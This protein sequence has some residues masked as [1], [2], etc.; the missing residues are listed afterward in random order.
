MADNRDPQAIGTPLGA[1]GSRVG[2]FARPALGQPSGLFG[3][4]ESANVEDRR[5]APQYAPYSVDQL[6]RQYNE[7]GAL[8]RTE[9]TKARMRDMLYEF[10]RR[11]ALELQ[12]SNGVD[13]ERMG[14]LGAPRADGGEVSE[15]EATPTPWYR[16]IANAALDPIQHAGRH[17]WDSLP[18]SWASSKLAQEQPNWFGRN[19]LANPDLSPAL[20]AAMF[21]G[22]AGAGRLAAAR[23]ASGRPI[24][25]EDDWGGEGRLRLAQEAWA[26]DSSPEARAAAWREFGWT[27]ADTWGDVPRR[28]A[29]PATVVAMPE[30]GFEQDL[31][32]PMKTDGRTILRAEEP[33]ANVARGVDD[34]LVAVPDLAKVTTRLTVDPASHAATGATSFN[35]IWEGGVKRHGYEPAGV[36]P[37]MITATGNSPA[38]IAR[39]F[40]HETTHGSAAP[41]NVAPPRSWLEA[42]H[43]SV[44]RGTK[45]EEILNQRFI[46]LQNALLATNNPRLAEKIAQEITRVEE[47]LVRAPGT[48]KY[49]SD[50]PERIAREADFYRVG[51]TLEENADIIPGQVDT[52]APGAFGERLEKHLGAPLP[53]FDPKRATGG[54]VTM[55]LL[56]G[57]KNIGHNIKAEMKA[58]KPQKQAIA[59]A[60]DV[61][62]RK[63]NGG[64][65]RGYADGG[66]PEWSGEMD[67]P[68]VAPPSQ[69][70]R[71]PVPEWLLAQQGSVRDEGTGQ[72]FPGGLFDPAIDVGTLAAEATGIPSVVRGAGRMGEEGVASKIRGGA[73]IAAGALP[74]FAVART[75]APLIAPFFKTMP[76]TF[77]TLA[78][79][80]AVSDVTDAIVS[81]ADAQ[82]SGPYNGPKRSPL[83]TKQVQ[84]EL[85]AAGVYEGEIDG[86]D[87]SATRHAER[88]L[89]EKKIENERARRAEDDARRL[90]AGEQQVQERALELQQQQLEKTKAD[91]EAARARRTIGEA[92]LKETEE[93][94]PWW[95]TAQRV[96]GPY[97]G[98]GLGLGLGYL[99]GAGVSRFGKYIDD[100]AVTRADKLL[101]GNRE[102][103]TPHERASDIN[104]FWK[105]G[106]P[107]GTN[108]P[109]ATTSTAPYWKAETKNV[110]PATDL[111]PPKSRGVEYG[112]NALLASAIGGGE[113]A[114]GMHLTSKAEAELEAAR[115]AFDKDQSDENIQRIQAA[116]DAVARG[117]LMENMGRMSALGQGVKG[118]YGIWKRP[119]TQPAINKAGAERAAINELLADKR[120]ALK[121]AKETKAQ[122]AKKSPSKKGYPKGRTLNELGGAPIVPLA[123]SQMRGSEPESEAISADASLRSDA[124][125]YAKGGEVKHHSH[126]QPR[127]VGKFAGGPVY[128]SKNIGNRAPSDKENG[129]GTYAA[130]GAIHSALNVARKYADGGDV[131]G[132]REAPATP[133]MREWLFQKTGSSI[134]ADLAE[135]GLIYGPLSMLG[136][137]SPKG[138]AMAMDASMVNKLRT[139][140]PLGFTPNGVTG[141]NPRWPSPGNDYRYSSTGIANEAPAE[142]MSSAVQPVAYPRFKDQ[143]H[144]H[145]NFNQATPTA[146]ELSNRDGVLPVSRRTGELFAGS[147]PPPETVIPRL[148]N[149]PP[150]ANDKAFG[151]GIA[152]PWQSAIKRAHSGPVIGATGGRE[153]AKP[154]SVRSGSF[155]IPADV[156]SGIGGGN[157]LAGLSTFEKMFKTGPYGM[158]LAKPA[159]SAPRNMSFSSSKTTT[160][161]ADGGMP[162]AEVPI[163]I[164]DGEYVVSPE[165]VAAIGNGD[166][167]QGHAILDKLVLQ[168]RRQNIKTLAS[169]P[170]PARD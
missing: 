67:S 61:A 87:G 46:E 154:I 128:P 84:Q 34:L 141:G 33:F 166:V 127:R 49:L 56:K 137:R 39:V 106:S 30:F 139:S 107:D 167:D 151:G 66:V 45:A 159:A 148:M 29:Q 64:G 101:K 108:P 24:R 160:K 48:A 17:V 119:H 80:R 145:D 6:L 138:S 20:N 132:R 5:P 89:Y 143:G 155:V 51:K 7:I 97:V 83:L 149:S 21:V 136:L 103:L 43:M 9:E 73:E 110:A 169:L 77:A 140:S 111:Y 152:S 82:E 162:Q 8:P 50:A 37:T 72:R 134:P 75:T 153:D 81:A 36:R 69:S 109:F 165:Q 62:R 95:S 19:I 86:V 53:S 63:A 31:L 59:I 96:A 170:P 94:L 42:Q 130:G 65:V 79:P 116:K 135:A 129:Q 78:A 10:E 144:R 28:K 123:T 27:P 142:A 22:P 11:G 92:K 58:G 52:Y 112:A 44:L 115:T 47:Q 35:P 1:E 15:P 117:N 3:Q 102:R 88:R 23:R 168:L 93:N 38:E 70:T 118:T 105:K 161:F 124:Q 114:A 156:V 14:K 146:A 12:H 16:S 122:A 99:G 104:T 131:S 163:Q 60:L 13:G 40:A 91:E 164:S 113:M 25:H 18:A 68:A 157:T 85:K 150:R 71:S 2:A 98:M 100:L 4:R 32:R 76:R 158:A 26:K 57:K 126:F 120:A 125:P 55:P 133:W 121:A 147:R 54:K 74:A 90:K 41:Q